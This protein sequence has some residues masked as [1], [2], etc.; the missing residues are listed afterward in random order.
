ME[1]FNDF[2]THHHKDHILG[3]SSL[4]ETFDALVVASDYV[5]QLLKK[6]FLH[7]EVGQ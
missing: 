7:Y 5:V 3:V 1:A 6:I 2:C 4:A